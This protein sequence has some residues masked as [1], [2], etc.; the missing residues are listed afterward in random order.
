MAS[1]SSAFGLS[2][3]SFLGTLLVGGAG[4][5]LAACSS[6]PAAAPTTAPAAAPTT[7]P[8]AAPTTAPAAAPTAAPAAAPTTAPAAAAAPTVAKPAATAVPTQAPAAGAAKT[9]I[10]FYSPA[11]DKLGKEII[12]K[13]ADQ[14]NQKSSKIQVKVTTVP[15]DNHYAKYVTAIAGGQ[16]P[17]T[18][19]TYDYSPIVDWAAQGFIVPL[20]AYQASM[21]IKPDDYF[22]VAW[23]MISFHGHLW[24]FL[25]EF[26]YYLLSWNKGLFQ[27]AGPDPEKAPKT[28]DEMDKLAEQLTVKDSSGNL[29]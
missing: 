6:A 15:T 24:G 11:T 16:A 28:T 14:Y 5:I 18:I 1:R 19:M 3:R 4:A 9:Q 20:D 17:D 7:A 22:P 29:K 26:D 10:E 27:K 12:A 2:R 13:L 23:N 25:Q 8:A 21:G